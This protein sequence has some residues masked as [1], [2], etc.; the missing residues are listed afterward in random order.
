M[1]LNGA[2]INA[3]DHKERSALHLAADLGHVDVAKVLVQYDMNAVDHN[4][5]LAADLG[6]VDVAKVLV[7]YGANVD[8]IT[9]NGRHCTSQLNMDM[10]TLRS[11]RC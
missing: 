7:Q 1:L 3:V 5:H 8:A 2:Y 6:H 10:L 11:V 4:E 9:K